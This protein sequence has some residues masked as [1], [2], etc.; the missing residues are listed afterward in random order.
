VG[1]TKPTYVSNYFFLAAAENFLRFVLV[2]LLNSPYKTTK[3]AIELKTEHKKKGGRKGHIFC[4]E[5]KR[6]KRKNVFPR[7]FYL[8]LLRNAPKRV[9]TNPRSK[10]KASGA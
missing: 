1:K 2:V 6:I 9:K 10:I 8:F 4:D 5:P 7:V 3:N